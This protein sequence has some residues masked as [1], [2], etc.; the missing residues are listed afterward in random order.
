[1]DL[2]DTYS[3]LPYDDLPSFIKIFL[4]N[5]GRKPLRG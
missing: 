1:V 5:D 4:L 2:L 3:F